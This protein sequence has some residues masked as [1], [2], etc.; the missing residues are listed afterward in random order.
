M[1]FHY[2]ILC[3][4]YCGLIFW[5]SGRPAPEVLDIGFDG[6][7]KLAHAAL[8]G[9]LAGLVSVGLRRSKAVVS[10]RVQ[11]LV[12]ACFAVLYGFS[13]ELHQ[14]FVPSRTAD[15]LDLLA[16]AAGVVAAQLILCRGVWGIPL[17]RL[18]AGSCNPPAPDRIQ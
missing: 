16:D 15:P 5:L 3:A 7:D 8:F 13:D 1:K 9:G 18:A 6:M 17:Q 10:P 14:A 4:L 12:P 11:Y 2:F